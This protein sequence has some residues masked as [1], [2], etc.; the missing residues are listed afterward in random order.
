MNVTSGKNDIWNLP[1]HHNSSHAWRGI[2]S[3]LNLLKQGLR[4]RISNGRT[5]QLWTDLWVGARPL[6][7]ESD[8]N[9]L[10]NFPRT[11]VY[12]LIMPGNAWDMNKI[13]AFFG[14]SI[15]NNIKAI[16]LPLTADSDDLWIWDAHSSS[17]LSVSSAYKMIFTNMNATND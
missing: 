9:L 4:K 13:N 10:A 12:D 3:G 8:L 5:T 7:E 1:E 16:P 6:I 15:C 14:A 2:V 17:R 11:H